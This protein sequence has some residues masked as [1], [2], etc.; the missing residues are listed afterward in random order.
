MA[1]LSIENLSLHYVTSRGTAR[2]VD[3]ASL[4]VERG[5][6]VGLVGESGCGKTTLARAVTGVL[7]RSARIAGG[8]ILF[9]G[10][11]LLTASRREANRLRW[12]EISFVPQTAMN[13]LDPVY[14]VGTQVMEVLTERG[15]MDKRK[16]KARAAELFEMVGIGVDRLNDYPHQFSGGMRQRAAIALGLALS[17][18]LVIADEP[19][20][21][22]DV[23]VQRQVL[24]LIRRLQQELSL[25]VI[26]V[27]HDISVVAYLCDAVAV[28]YA[29]KVA[30]VGRAADV[31]NAPDHP[32]TMGLY[33]AFPDL[34]R[35]Q[36]RLTPIAGAPPSLIDPPAGCRFEP[37]CP[38][39]VDRCRLEPQLEE[40]RA[41]HRAAC[42]RTGDAA[43]LRVAAADVATW[44]T[45]QEM[46]A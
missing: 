23:V 34:E 7:P 4:D 43:E 45:K 24:D 11:D 5:Q 35:S 38:F 8:R 2:A 26:I 40:I 28:M 21:A 33:N 19:V 25:S 10:M 20:T 37:R 36:S 44:E 15:G 6:V 18:K 13:S 30:E 17:P 3:G 1:L 12:R 39:R 41:G 22:L 14:R 27:T 46:P 9:E 32:Y 42:W 29:G 31:L 16:A